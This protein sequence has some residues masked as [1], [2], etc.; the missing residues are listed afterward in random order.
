MSEMSESV[1]KFFCFPTKLHSLSVLSEMSEKKMP[2]FCRKTLFLK[3]NVF[4]I[5]TYY[6]KQKFV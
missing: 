6:S 4:L 2:L 5:D 3:K 1:G